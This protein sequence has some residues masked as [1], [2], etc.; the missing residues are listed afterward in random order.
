[1]SKG[2]FIILIDWERINETGGI[3]VARKI[4][5]LSM[6][7]LLIISCGLFGP[8]EENISLNIQGA[9]TD[10]ND[11]SPLEKVTV[12]LERNG[13]EYLSIT[14]TDKDGK[15]TLNWEGKL[16]CNSESLS[17]EV[18]TPQF[19][20]GNDDRSINCSSGDLIINFEMVKIR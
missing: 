1:M 6:M 13:W 16:D 3:M 15:Y 9:V 11:E 4:I 5:A 7:F 18:V 10:A 8:K 12:T 2:T 19:D 14:Y 20:Y 17:V